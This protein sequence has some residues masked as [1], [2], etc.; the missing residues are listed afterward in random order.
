MATM[1][2]PTSRPFTPGPWQADLSTWEITTNPARGPRVTLALP[3]NPS[4]SLLRRADCTANA[5]LIAAAPDLYTALHA[6]L[7]AARASHLEEWLGAELAQAEQA[8]ALAR[9]Q[10]PGGE[11]D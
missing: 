10:G 1:T 11:Q 7:V 2:E 4:F 3:C 6:L 8:L 5:H 9:G